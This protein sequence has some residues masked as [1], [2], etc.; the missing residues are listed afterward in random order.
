MKNIIKLKQ[1]LITHKKKIWVISALPLAMFFSVPISLILL[2]VQ[3]SCFAIL[4]WIGWAD[5]M[6]DAFVRFLT[7]IKVL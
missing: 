6:P 3:V 4:C 7:K 2:I 5:C 1:F